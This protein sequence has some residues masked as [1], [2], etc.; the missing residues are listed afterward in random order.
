MLPAFR[1]FL[2]EIIDY[3]GLFP[4]AALDLDPAIRNHVRYRQSPEAWM[5][6]RFIVPAA[7][8]SALDAY[9]DLF[10]QAPPVGF[11]V[12]GLTDASGGLDGT[13]RATLEAA[14]AFEARHPGRVRCD[15]FELRAA[16]EAA[17]ALA[18]VL[19]DLP[20]ADGDGIAVEFPMTGD[21]Y[22]PEVIEE[23]AHGIAEANARARE[24]RFAL[25][26]RCGGVT[27]DLVPGVERLADAV[28]ACAKADAPFKATAGLHHP[29]RNYDEAVGAEMHG[30]MN[31]FGA[32][33]LALARG[34]DRDAIAEVLDDGDGSHFQLG[35]AFA[36][37]GFAVEAAGVHEARQRRALSYGSCSFDEPIEDLRALGWMAP[38][39]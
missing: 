32:A 34:F 26:L 36:W 29:F 31:L 15:R 28:A 27:P 6:G 22:A 19:S 9:A 7:R 37:R 4:P 8:L 24:K 12:L 16:P 35:D 14:R 33:T 17:G 11:S 2:T 20:L 25:K 13:A 18:A 3:A 30:F 10:A 1:A 21:G 5:L 23:A 38:A 39:E